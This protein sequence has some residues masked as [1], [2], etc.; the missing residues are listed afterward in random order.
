ML[1][2]TEYGAFSIALALVATAQNLAQL[3]ISV[4]LIRRTEAEWTDHTAFQALT[5]LVSVG[6]AMS[7][8]LWALSATTLVVDAASVKSSVRF[9]A[10]VLP[11]ALAGQVPAAILERALRYK[12]IA[13]AELYGQV[14]YLAVGLISVI[15]IAKGTGLALA[16]MAQQIVTAAIVCRSARFI[17]KL[18]NPRPALSLLRDA[19]GYSMTLWLWQFRGLVIPMV[20]VPRCGLAAAGHIA[21]ATRVVE[22]VAFTRAAA[23]RL[24]IATLA[25]VQNDRSALRALLKTAMQFQVI[26]LGAVLTV[27]SVAVQGLPLIIGDAWSRT[28][29]LVPLLGVGVLSNAA[30]NI[31]TSVL[32][33][34]KRN[35]AVG[36]FHGVHIVL[37]AVAAAA[38][39]SRYGELGYGYAEI[40]ATLAYVVPAVLV[41]R[42][43]GDVEYRNTMLMLCGFAA[44]LLSLKF[45]AIAG[46][47]LLLLACDS[48]LRRMVLSQ[49]LLIAN[50]LRSSS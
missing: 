38:L 30:F 25:K 11:V 50:G 39:T 9:M 41:K 33:V 40:I 3:G 21:V 12:A 42:E 34:R 26:V 18:S 17:P 8:T 24:S 2:A 32:Y 29:A 48:T 22:C 44:C 43:I 10:L 46:V 14:T 15:W 31:H 45:G 28:A 13:T 7:G 35:S 6:A 5:L 27:A 1:G 36:V 19:A 23:W 37:L 16:W 20:V 47:P 4:T 49:S